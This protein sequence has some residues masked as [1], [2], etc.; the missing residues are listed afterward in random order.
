MGKFTDK[1]LTGTVGPVVIYEMYGQKYARTKPTRNKE[2]R[3]KN[4]VNMEFGSISKNGSPMVK[5]LKDH[6]N[7]SFPMQLQSYNDL[8]K[9]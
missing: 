6:G 1:G 7:F 4:P 8:R 3:K 5:Y 9:R 2:K